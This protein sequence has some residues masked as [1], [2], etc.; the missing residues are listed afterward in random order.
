MALDF[1]GAPA[2]STDVE[3]L[4][5]HLGLVCAKR[6]HNLNAENIKISTTLGNWTW[7]GLVPL[8][9][10][11]EVLNTKY[12]KREVPEDQWSDSEGKDSEVEVE[13]E[14]EGDDF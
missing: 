11:Q 9:K 6:H 7:A 13:G 12:G 3:H 8:K 1:L 10:T 4:F 5:S 2:T 14:V